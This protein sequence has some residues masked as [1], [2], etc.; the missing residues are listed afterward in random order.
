MFV[1]A[2]V[3][4]VVGFAAAQARLMNL[5]RRGWLRDAS[6]TAYEQW[7]A[8]MARVGPIGPVPGVSR[9][10]EVRFRDLVRHGD[11]AMLALRWEATGSGA[12]LFPALDADI[13]LTPDGDSTTLLAMSGA[14]RPPLGKLGATIDRTILRRVTTATTRSFL[15]GIGNA[16]S[17]PATARSGEYVESWPLVWQ[18]P[19]A[20][21]GA[22]QRA[23]SISLDSRESA[24]PTPVRS[25]HR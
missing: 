20:L 10:V 17:N 18:L 6:D 7:H 8:S 21:P 19:D 1:Q 2:E 13:T 15:T 24:E 11:T 22:G 3:R 12:G 25:S 9:L 4:L 16:I 14:Y 23:R 5:A